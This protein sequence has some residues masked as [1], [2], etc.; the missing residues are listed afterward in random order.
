MGPIRKMFYEHMYSIYRWYLNE[1]QIGSFMIEKTL[2]AVRQA[3][4]PPVMR[5]FETVWNVPREFGATYGDIEKSAV[6]H[7]MDWTLRGPMSF[8][9]VLSI[10]LLIFIIIVD[11]AIIILFLIL[12]DYI[13]REMFELWYEIPQTPLPVRQIFAVTMVCGFGF[14]LYWLKR[15]KQ[16]I[17]ALLEISLSIIIVWHGT[18]QNTSSNEEIISYWATLISAVYFF[19]RGLDNLNRALDLQTSEDKPHPP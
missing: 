6:G 18:D 5:F 4:A 12:M 14:S 1:N 15:N 8:A 11:L 3:Y 9:R 10:F 17:Y 13:V 7:W 16:F 19:I 2:Y